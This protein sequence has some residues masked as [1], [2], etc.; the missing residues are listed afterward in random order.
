MR[1]AQLNDALVKELDPQIARIAQKKTASHKSTAL[2]PQLPFAQLVEKRHQEDITRTYIDRHKPGTNSTFS[3]LIN[4]I[5]LD[6][7]H[8]TADD[9]HMTEQDI[10]QGINVVRHKY[11]K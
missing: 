5:S 4:N 10:A 3:S 2:K 8:L 11:S 6:I 9:I 7:D 1:N